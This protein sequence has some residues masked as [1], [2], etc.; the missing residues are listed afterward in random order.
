VNADAVDPQIG[1]HVNPKVATDGGQTRPD[2]CTCCN[3]T[4][5]QGPPCFHCYRVGFRTPA[6]GSE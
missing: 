3:W 6:V 2:D 1:E 5:E 4:L